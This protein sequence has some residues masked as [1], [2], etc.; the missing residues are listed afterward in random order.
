MAGSRRTCKHPRCPGF[1][2]GSGFCPEHQAEAWKPRDTRVSAARRGYDF[3]WRVWAAGFRKRHP[4]CEQCPGPTQVV[5]HR[6]TREVMYLKNGGE[7]FQDSD[8]AGLCHYHNLKKAR[9][10]D[11][12]IREQYGLPPGPSAQGVGG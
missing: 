5:D 8:Y 11:P 3:K 1:A 9:E 6:E 4:I 2:D 10:V 7:T 12:L